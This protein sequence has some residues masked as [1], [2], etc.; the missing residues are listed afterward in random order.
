MENNKGQKDTDKLL[1]QTME[2]SDLIDYQ[3]GSIV[4]RTII[5][6]ATG[7]CTLFAFDSGQ[8]LS[9]H[10]APFDALVYIP[11]GEAEVTI[12]GKVNQLTKGKMIVMPANE[13]HALRA[14]KK[15]KMMLVMIKS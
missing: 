15:F 10:T 2:L 1:G 9:E 11:D 13:P 7:T 12:S 5:D 14:V 6:K 4:S 3:E 8:G